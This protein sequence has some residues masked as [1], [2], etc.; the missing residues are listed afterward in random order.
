MSSIQRFRFFPT[1]GVECCGCIVVSTNG[2]YAELRAMSVALSSA[3][4][5]S[6]FSVVS[7]R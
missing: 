5:V 3:S 2:N 7:C 1:T 6:G 4:F